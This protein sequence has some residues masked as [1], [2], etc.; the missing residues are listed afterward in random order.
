MAA[1][2]KSWPKQANLREMSD[3]QIVLTWKEAAEQLFRLRLAGANRA[4]RCAQ[5]IAPP[6]PLIA[7]CQTILNERKAKDA[8]GGS[9]TKS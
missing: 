5:R 8:A 4:A 9:L 2:R 1:E 7:R 6:A 3:E